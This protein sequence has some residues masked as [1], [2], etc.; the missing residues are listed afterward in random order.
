MT[1]HEQ[2]ISSAV[3]E[4]LIFRRIQFL[5]LTVPTGW[6]VAVALERDL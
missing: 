2:L 6:S 4:L 1:M 5:V 3:V